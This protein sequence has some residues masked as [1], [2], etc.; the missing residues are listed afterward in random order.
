MES[1]KFNRIDS[2]T[3]ENNGYLIEKTGRGYTVMFRNEYYSFPGI[4][5]AA[6]FCM[7]SDDAKREYIRK[8][9]RKA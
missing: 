6:V 9:A 8:A 3:T 1:M 2:S 4:W 5:P 7:A